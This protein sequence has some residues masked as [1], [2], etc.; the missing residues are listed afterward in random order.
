MASGPSSSR[1]G[2]ERLG[3]ELPVAD[4]E[5]TPGGRG[6]HRRSLAV[7]QAATV[8]AVELPEVD[9]AFF[10]AVRRRKTGSAGRR[11]G[12]SE[13]H[14]AG[15]APRTASPRPACRRQWTGAI[16]ALR[17][18]RSTTG[19]RR[20]SASRRRAPPPRRPLLAPS[21]RPARRG[22]VVR[23]RRT[24]LNARRETRT[25]RSRCR[26][27]ERPGLGDVEAAQPQTSSTLDQADERHGAAIRRDG[28]GRV[29]RRR[30]V[31]LQT[32]LHRR[33]RWAVVSPRRRLPRP[34]P[35]PPTASHRRARG[36]TVD[37]GVVAGVPASSSSRPA[38]PMSLSRLVGVLA[39][40]ALQQTTDGLGRVVGQQAPVGIRLQHRRH[41]L[42][43]RPAVECLSSTEHLVDHASEG[44]DI[45]AGVHRLADGLFGAHVRRG[46]DDDAFVRRPRR[47]VPLRG[48]RRRRLRSVRSPSPARSRAP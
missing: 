32:H 16:A 45:R 21:R 15:A 40:T 24:R 23:L 39:K 10:R 33:G 22:S 41:G 28:Q 35:R 8:E 19:R 14:A 1:R 20:C 42:A 34:L 30:R 18:W 9:A 38:S 25:V 48:L 31:E 11:A 44:P 36:A 46:A 37:G 43:G 3:Q 12:N 2:V 29:D 13:K 17:D 26:C 7:E 47:S 6:K 5:Q 27:R 4:E